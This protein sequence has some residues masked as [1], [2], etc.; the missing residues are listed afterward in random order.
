MKDIESLLAE[1]SARPRRALRADF[2]N[3]V[4]EH[5]ASNPRPRGFARLKEIRIMKLLTKPAIAVAAITIAIVASGT[6]YAAMGLPGLS[7]LFGGSQHLSNGDR[8][9]RVDT[10]NCTYPS[11]FTLSGKTKPSNTLYYRVKNGA[12]LT[13]DQVVQLV[14]GNCYVQQ[15][16]DYDGQT[17]QKLLD[18]NPL[19]KDTVVG[20]YID[21][22][23]TAIS[24]ASLSIKFVIPYNTELRKVDQ[25]FSHVA[26]DVVVFGN[27]QKLSLNDVHV[28]DHV[29]IKYRAS[30]DALNHSE[31]LPLD[32]INTDQQVVVAILKNT[33]DQTA[34]VNYTKYNGTE[35]EQVVPC[36]WEVSGY[37]NYEQYATRK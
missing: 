9:V 5:L 31:T 10:Q 22:E 23:V 6:A 15:Q 20:G 25:T 4:I 14:R 3:T 18:T 32:Q 11:A 24:G 28:G 12:K 29:S 16:A 37:C 17:I 30:G 21:S 13:D 2:T 8:I 33:T 1:S 7:A 27:S 26:P 35:F 19:N 36:S 34:A